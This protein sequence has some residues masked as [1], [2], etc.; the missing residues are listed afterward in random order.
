MTTSE[1]PVPAAVRI[2]RPRWRDPRLVVGLVL[3]CASV[4]L[5][6]VVVSHADDRAPVFAAR[7]A[8]VP[9]QRIAAGD[10]TRVRVQLGAEEER[11]LRADRSLAPDRFVLREVR[12]G[13]L[14]PVASVGDR[15][16]VAVQPVTVSVEPGSAATLMVGSQVDVYVNPP[17]GRTPGASSDGGGPAS[18]R[19]G[20]FSGPELTLHAVSVAGLPA[21]GGALG[22]GSGLRPVQVMAPTEA[23]RGLIAKVDEGSKVTLVPVPGTTLE[24]AQ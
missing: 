2:Q 20:A 21:Q 5:G 6:S 4:A 16:S 7:T 10:L 24:S 17:A 8:L 22:S 9:G 11:Y 1:L 14:V 15:A 19:G 12:P 23:I 18:S 3:V 13:E